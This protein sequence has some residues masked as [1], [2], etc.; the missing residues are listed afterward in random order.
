MA[1]TKPD[2]PA[3]NAATADQA[4]TLPGRIEPQHDENG[5]PI[6][7]TPPHG[8]SWIR[9]EDGGLRPADQHTA[10]GAGLAWPS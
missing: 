4:N 7:L 6:E 8:G 9:E 1:K 5:Q 2:L 3:S 10:E